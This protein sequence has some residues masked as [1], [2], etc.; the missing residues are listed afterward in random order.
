MKILIEIQDNKAAH[1]LEILKELSFV[2]IQSISDEKT[3]LKKEILDAVEEMNEIY[4][5]KK[6][7]RDA[8]EFL[9][10]L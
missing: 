3:Q 1:L 9:D 6:E 2:K 4:E 8:D 5:G 7:G 10:E